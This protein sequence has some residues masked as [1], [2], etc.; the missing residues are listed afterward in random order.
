M[1]TALGHKMKGALWAVLAGFSAAAW[2]AANEQFIPIPSYRTGPMNVAGVPV[3]NGFIDYLDLINKRDGGVN[4]VKLTWEE[5]ET[6]YQVD[7]GVECYER[8]KKKGPTGASLYAP[9]STGII[10]AVTERATAD[11]I[12]ILT[13]G[14]GRTDASDGRVFPYVFTLLANYWSQNT[15]KIKF[16]GMR[17]GGM[18]KLKG[19]K[20]ANLYHGSPYGKETLPLLEQQARKYG[21]DLINI[22]IPHPGTD[23]QAQWL[24][25]RQAKPDW[26]IFRGFGVMNSVGIKTAQKVGFPADR[27]IGAFPSS[28]EEDV[29]PAGDAAKGY[30]T[31]AISLSGTQYP[32][33]QEIVKRLY[34]GGNKGRMENTKGIGTVYYNLGV[35][36]GVIT[37]ET[38]RVG[39]E[40]FGKKPLTGEQVRWALE[41]LSI[42]EKRLKQLGA[43]VLMQPL[44]VSCS[45]HEGGG[46]VKFQQWDGQKWNS[47]S[48]WI[49]ADRALVRPM[50]EGVAAKYAREKGIQLRDCSKDS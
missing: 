1:K 28:A 25:V 11:K 10:Y 30:I 4:G 6:A 39:Q 27:I 47:V 5:C 36:H 22:E 17:E 38:I 12:P 19:K 32:V 18:D 34:G 26:V 3:Y 43:S 37:A 48:D 49:E 35:I 40:K 50:V 45:D 33:I 15:A 46:L 7:R 23:Q 21:F 42:D 20:I 2:G 31:V 44:K 14:Y 13:M 9:G 24:Q 8:L 29:I 41:H 16:I